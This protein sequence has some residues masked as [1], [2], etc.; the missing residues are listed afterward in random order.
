[1]NSN[2]TKSIALMSLLTV[3]LSPYASP[4]EIK[5]VCVDLNSCVETVSSLT[6]KSYLYGKDLKGTIKASSNLLIDKKNA[7]RVLSEILNDAGY[8]RVPVNDK[9]FR[10]ISARDVRYT[11][12]PQ[13]EASKKTA[14]NLPDVAD[15][16]M[17]TYTMKNPEVSTSITRSLRPFMSR[18][19]RIID[20]KPNG[21][22][23]VQDTALNIKRL[24]KLVKSMDVKPTK[25]QLKRWE[26]DRKRYHELE[27]QRAKHGGAKK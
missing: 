12:V 11:P 9:T 14:P 10:I 3:S 8:T 13:I 22:L 16:F 2:L 5:K 23:V 19:G 17:M 15:Y 7:D 25:A 20:F 1:M 4:L 6:G 21:T 27:L 24:Y 26:R 18:Y